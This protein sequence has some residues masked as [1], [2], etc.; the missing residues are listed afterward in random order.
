MTVAPSGPKPVVAPPPLIPA[1]TGLIQAA[2][3]LDADD[4]AVFGLPPGTTPDPEPFP[5][6]RH[7]T[8]D[9][10]NGVK[11]SPESTYQPLV[12]QANPPFGGGVSAPTDDLTGGR[13]LTQRVHHPYWIEAIDRSSTFGFE[14][15]DYAGR[16]T[17][18]L[19]AKESTILERYFEGAGDQ[20]TAATAT[21]SPWYTEPHLAGGNVFYPDGATTNLSAVVS[22]AYFS[23]NDAGKKITGTGIPANTTILSASSSTGSATLSA[24]ATATGS[25]LVFTLASPY[26][27]ALNA[28]TTP[29]APA[30]GF[31]LLQE[32]I[33]E[34]NIGRGMIHC[35]A[36]LAERFAENHAMRFGVSEDGITALTSANGNLV[37]AGNGYR[38]IG[39]DSPATGGTLGAYPTTAQVGQGPSPYSSSIQ[40][41]YAT[42]MVRIVR[43]AQPQLTP[44]PDGPGDEWAQA[45][46]QALDRRSN[47][48][49]IRSYRPYVVEWAGL[50]HAA[51]AISATA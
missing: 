43:A 19:I 15:S 37:V 13:H 36:F 28:A 22:S 35:T 29:V 46:R 47:L 14:A 38:G 48:L 31:A 10:W 39:P 21:T 51:V 25:A 11:Y 24:A 44:D 33:G 23:E 20:A 17:R 45:F 16:A 27:V 30:I 6:G 9:V 5:F 8:D 12:L 18:A 7:R 1:P 2:E 32:A 50:C 26:F 40:W 49:T 4:P 42:D 41:A 3:V 34:A